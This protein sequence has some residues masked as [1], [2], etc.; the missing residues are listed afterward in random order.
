ML[1]RADRH[2][3]F[4]VLG[5]WYGI[6]MARA[7]SAVGASIGGR[8]KIALMKDLSG[9]AALMDLAQWAGHTCLPIATAAGLRSI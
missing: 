4:N 2:C 5:R 1:Q 8:M 3:L 6:S 7:S 9:A